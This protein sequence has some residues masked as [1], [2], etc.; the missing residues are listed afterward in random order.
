MGIAFALAG[1]ALAAREEAPEDEGGTRT[2]A[3]TGLALVAALGF[4]SFFVAMDR[5]SEG[6]AL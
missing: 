4:G 6:D 2:A 1:V 5:A 3:G